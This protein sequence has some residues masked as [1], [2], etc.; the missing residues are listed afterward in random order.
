MSNIHL[1]KESGLNRHFQARW[2]SAHVVLV[3]SIIGAGTVIV[4]ADLLNLVMMPRIRT[5]FHLVQ[6]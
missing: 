5:Q 3:S 1:L 6:M 2:A 4:N